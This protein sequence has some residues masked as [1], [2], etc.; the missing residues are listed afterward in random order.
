MKTLN[1]IALNYIDFEFNKSQNKH[2]TLVSYADEQRG[3]WLHK[4]PS[5]LNSLKTQLEVKKDEIFV[6]YAATA[7]A[8]CFLALGLEPTEFK[9][10][11]LYLEYCHLLNHNHRLAY[12]KQ[13]K[14]GK[15]VRTTPPPRNKWDLTEEEKKK[16]DNSKPEK[17]YAAACFKLLGELVDTKEK[18][19]VRDLIISAPETFTHEERERIVKYN[20][21][22]IVFPPRLLEAILNEYKRLL[23][24][25]YNEERLIKEMLY[26]GEYAAR[27][28]K[29]E[30]IGYPINVEMTRNFSDSVG[31]ILF[32]T[33]K[34]INDL[35]PDIKPFRLKPDYTYSLTEA[36]VRKWIESTGLAPKW[37]KTKTKQLSLSMD[38]FKRHFDFRHNYPKDNFGAQFVRYLT[39]KQNINGFSPTA[40]NSFWDYVGDDGRVRPYF[41]IYGAQSSR[42]QPKATGYLFLKSAWMRVMCQPPKGRAVG[43]TDYGQEE[44]L[45]IGLESGDMNMVE[46]YYSG[47]PYLYFAKK[48]KAVPPEATKKSHGQVRDKFK[49]TTLS[50]QYGQKAEGMSVKLTNDLGYYVS[51]EE[52]QQIIDLFDRVFPKVNP[53]K[54]NIYQRYQV[55]R[56]LKLP[57]G[58]YIWGDNANGLSVKNFP[59]QGIGASIMRRAVRYA[60]DA[61]LDVILTLHDALYIEFD[62]DKAVESMSKLADCMQRAFQD[63][64]KKHQGKYKIKMD[65]NI[66][67]PDYKDGEIEVEGLGKVKVQNEYI[68]ERG[69]KEYEFFKRYFKPEQVP[70]DL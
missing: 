35:F 38:A 53:Y 3:I 4:K 36:N 61:G 1:E 55:K 15:V 22:D 54:E 32:Q 37:M 10:I 6:S 58:W 67:S 70:E 40:K 7:E 30:S 49:G 27:T 26:R 28:A 69:A 46:A 21:S 62:S 18:D 47:D 20:K 5:A 12:G 42:S 59:I 43:A 9:W 31:K 34:E 24:K 16:Q 8:R 11:D 60:Q 25:E 19:E 51:P 17:G 56:K 64:Y 65:G 44:F 2:P 63:H 14:K 66:W 29:M 39:L 57:D 48:A 68:D 33:Q 45:L 13:L 52:C 50:M 41:G 23:G